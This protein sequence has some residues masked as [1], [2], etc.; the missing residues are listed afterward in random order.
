MSRKVSCGVI[1]AG[2]WAT[3]AHIPALLQH[4]QAHLIGL[5]TLG[6]ERAE[7]IAHHFGVANACETAEE[8][9]ALPG[10]EAVVISS[11]PKLHYAHAK[12]A[13]LADKHVLLEKPMTFHAAEA[14]E[15]VQI[16]AK[17]GLQFL[18]SCPWHFTAHA[19]EAQQAIRSG[20]IG[21]VR[22]MSVL[23]TNPVSALLRG[24]ENRTTYGKPYVLPQMSTYCDP[25]ISG[26]GQSY[27]Q[28]SHVAAYLAFLTG[29]RASHVFAR[30]H[31]DGER[32]DMYDVIS[33]RME[34]GA[35]AS[36]ASTGVTADTQRDFEVR[37]FGTKAI[38]FLDLWRGTMRLVRHDGSVKEFP[39]LQPGMEYPHFA[40]AQNL[41]DS[42]IDPSVNR[43]PATLGVAA[44]E[45]I[46]AAR[47]SAETGRDIH[48]AE[49]RK[50]KP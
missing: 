29:C 19:H 1:G 14:E 47:I 2:W 13:L 42:I 36:I 17:R 11:V 39:P 21:E 23:M 25:E 6:R 30:F 27:A 46:E 20:E 49:L 45:I 34:N 16:A 12:A 37:I 26:G 33:L 28:V 3:L 10:L 35:L 43:S 31:N 48:V 32:I 41:I 5:Q 38:I 44:M 22:M 9:L 24:E 40:P 4:P 15:L 7:E 8:L 50:A 18:I